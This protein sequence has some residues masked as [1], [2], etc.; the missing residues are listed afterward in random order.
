MSGPKYVVQNMTGAYTPQTCALALRPV[1]MEYI[2]DVALCVRIRLNT[3]Q[4]SPELFAD[5]LRRQDEALKD[6]RSF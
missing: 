1:C 4:M 5:L 6:V 3:L 2:C